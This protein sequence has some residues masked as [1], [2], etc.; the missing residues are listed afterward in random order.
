M[1]RHYGQPT[2]VPPPPTHCEQCGRRLIRRDERDGYGINDG[3]PRLQTTWRC[4]LTVG[5]WNRVITMKHI[6]H[7]EYELDYMFEWYWRRREY[8]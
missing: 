2:V 4:P 8:I 3:K 1:E 7:D 6:L 5:L